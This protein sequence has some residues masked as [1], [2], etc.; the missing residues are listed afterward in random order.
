[1]REQI[2][3]DKAIKRGRIIVNVPAFVVIMGCPVLALFLIQ[4]NLIPVWGFPIAILIGFVLGWLVW[5]IMITKWRIWAFEHVRNVH[6]LKKRAIQEKL[7]WHAGSIFEKTE[8][9]N[10]EDKRKLKML[11]KKFEQEDEYKEDFSLPPKM[12]IYYAKAKSYFELGVSIVI[13]G[14]GIFLLA[15]EENKQ[16]VLGTIMMA[17]GLYST[18][19]GSR[20]AFNNEPQIIIDSKGI[21]TRNVAFKNWST[22]KG[23]EVVQ[24]SHGK[25]AKFYLTYSYEGNEFEK[26]EIDSLNVKPRALENILR[27]YRIRNTKNRH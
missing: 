5:G 2:T 8:I 22:I 23:E 1:M 3:V 19:K 12:E 6:E 26:L 9:R 27:T 18:V 21:K 7:I 16:Y 17:I 15:K 4:Q 13:M 20:K 10:T 25:S 14:L 11:E 24:E